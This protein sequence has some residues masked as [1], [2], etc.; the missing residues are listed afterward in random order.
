LTFICQYIKTIFMKGNINMEKQK[1]ITLNADKRKVIADVFQDHF[2]SNSKYKKAWQDAKDKYVV[3]R[4]QAKTIMEKL[5]RKHQPQEDVDTIRAMNNKYGSSGG[6]LYH[7]NCFYVSNELPKI[8]EDYQG[9]KREEHDDVHIKFGDMDKDFLTSYYRD[10]IK[11]KGI[12]ADYDV[13]LGDNYEKR[14]PTYYNSESAVNKF[15][16]FGSRNDVSKSQMFPKDEWDNDFKLWVIGTSYCHSR[17]FVADNETFKWF[18]SFKVAQEDVVKTHQQMFDHVNKKMEKLKLGLK[19]YRY[20][21]QAKE[22][23]DKLGVVL[24]ES[25]LDAHSSMA[26]SIYSPSNLA[27]LLTDEVEQTREE[28]IAIAKQLLQ[29]QQNSLN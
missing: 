22:L 13:R 19:S 29:E 24:N 3:M 7:D 4:N 21:N 25:I 15:L 12:D 20:F 1:R 10:E 6:E 23:A 26:L 14:N 5:I 16:G 17:K 11:A 28:K 9:N 27:D 18:E 2:E 8:V